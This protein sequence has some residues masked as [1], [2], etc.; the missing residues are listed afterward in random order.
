MPTTHP[1]K[2]GSP[3]PHLLS[4]PSTCQQTPGFTRLG[5]AQAHP[6]GLFPPSSKHTRVCLA[7]CVL[8]F[9]STA[10]NM[11]PSW[12]SGRHVPAQNRSV[13]K[14]QISNSVFG[15]KWP[16]PSCSVLHLWAPPQACPG[17]T[18]V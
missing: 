10:H 14:S 6:T 15:P 8:P 16:G 9:Y 2:H 13:T 1:A 12:K 5:A 17:V 3:H 11:R 7:D 4:S 18:A